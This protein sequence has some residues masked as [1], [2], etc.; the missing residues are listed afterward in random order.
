MKIKK[1]MEG[2]REGGKGK[3]GHV[4]EERGSVGPK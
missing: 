1:V 3:E 2:G 4:G